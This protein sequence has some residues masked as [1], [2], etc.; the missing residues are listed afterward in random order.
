[1]ALFIGA[2]ISKPLEPVD[3]VIAVAGHGL[4]GDRKYRREGLPADKNGPDREL[5]LIE[6]EA[7]EAV[8]R[9]YDVDRPIETSRNVLTRGVALESPGGQA[10]PGR[11]GD[12]GGHAALRAVR[13]PGVAHSPG[14][15]GGPGAPRRSEGP[16]S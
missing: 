4:E 11:R 8:N 9:D 10:L 6:A 16:D 15:A 1:M 12:A 3:Q 7:I 5:T 2:K 13:A 14:R